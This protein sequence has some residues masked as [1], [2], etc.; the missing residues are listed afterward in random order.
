MKRGEPSL[1]SHIL[2]KGLFPSKTRA[3]TKGSLPV[4]TAE[5]EIEDMSTRRIG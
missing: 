3:D 1:A 2:N 5:G 4:A